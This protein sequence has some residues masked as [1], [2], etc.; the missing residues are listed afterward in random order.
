GDQHRPDL[1]QNP[2]PA[3]HRRNQPWTVLLGP[4][5]AGNWSH[6]QP[7]R[8]RKMMPLKVR[9]QWAGGRPVPLRG[10]NSLRIGS[11]RRH[12]S[13]GTSPSWR[14]CGGSPIGYTGCSI[15][16]RTSTRRVAVGRLVREAA[17]R[18]VPELVRAMDQ[19]DA[20]RSPKLLAYLNSPAGRRVRT[21]NHVERT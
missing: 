15:P 17:F 3:A 16:P 20:E 6:S 18:A 7:V 2:P 5:L 12:S 13:S 8:M 19:L 10:Q 1:L 11:I 9:R 21:N 14:R 4:Y